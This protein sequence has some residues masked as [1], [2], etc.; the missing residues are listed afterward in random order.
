MAIFQF[1][2]EHRCKVIHNEYKK[3]K[4]EGLIKGPTSQGRKG[5][6]GKVGEGIIR[7]CSLFPGLINWLPLS[8]LKTNVRLIILTHVSINAE[9]LVQV[10]QACSEIIG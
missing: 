8:D 7:Q 5:K 10:G 1:F 2:V 3:S 6:E 9:T 4:T